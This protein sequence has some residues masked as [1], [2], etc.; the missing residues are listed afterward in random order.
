VLQEPQRPCVFVLG[1]AKVEDR[2]PVMRRVLRDGISDRILIGGLIRE[3]FHMAQGHDPGRLATLSE[4]DRGLVAEAGELMDR[5]GDRI[6]M[7]VDV[8]LDVG[9]ERLELHVSKLTD[10]RNIYDIGL[11]DPGPVLRPGE[12]GRDGC[13]RGAA[14]HVREEVLRCRDEGDP[15]GDGGEQ[16]VHRRRRRAPRGDGVDDGH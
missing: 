5:Y 6:E 7:P 9:G 1:G 8:A 14:G 10:E 12:K 13:R 4:Q 3:A 15:Q 16:G 2:L 11:N